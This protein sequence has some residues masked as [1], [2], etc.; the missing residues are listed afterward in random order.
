MLATAM[1]ALVMHAGPNDA[2]NVCHDPKST[3]IIGHR[4][5]GSSSDD[6]AFAENT[7][8]S[9]EN[10]FDEG[11]DMVE[12]DVHLTKDGKVALLHDFSL[13]KTTNLEGCIADY[14]YAALATADATIGSA[15]ATQVGVPLLSEAL[16]V[17]KQRGKKLNIEIKVNPSA[18]ACPATDIP[19]LAAAILAEVDAS[20]IKEDVFVSSFSFEMLENIKGLDAA[21]PVGLLTAEGDEVLLQQA[22]DAKAAGFEAI[23]PFFLMVTVSETLAALQETGLHVNPWTVNEEQYIGDLIAAG[24]DAVITDDVPLAVAAREAAEPAI[25]PEATQAAAGGNDGGQGGC[26]S[27][28]S[29]AP[30]AA[31]IL[32]AAAFAAR[33]LRDAFAR[34]VGGRFAN[35]QNST[36]A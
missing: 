17:V 32:A 28:G 5:S 24:V 7:I 30:P 34:Q 27:G 36:P 31:L 18:G 11:A 1:L 21:V 14:D 23:N 29:S 16:T 13:D 2:A 12:I 8:P 3:L 25:C 33:R 19:A 22:A 4:G 6:N 10:A 9:I 35:R 15:A 26:A 20:G